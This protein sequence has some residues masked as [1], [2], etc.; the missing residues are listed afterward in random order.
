MAP[1]T[2]VDLY[3]DS[4]YKTLLPGYGDEE[5]L[6]A[7]LGAFI[8][9]EDPYI[10]TFEIYLSEGSVIATVTVSV[11]SADRLRAMFADCNVCMAFR[12][13][14]VCPRLSTV[15]E[16]EL[17]FGGNPDDEDPDKR[18]VTKIWVPVVILLL[19][20]ILLVFLCLLRRRRTRDDNS[21]EKNAWVVEEEDWQTSQKNGTVEYDAAVVGLGRFVERSANPLYMQGTEDLTPHYSVPNKS[22]VTRAADGEVAYKMAA[23][24]RPAEPLPAYATVENSTNDQDAVDYSTAHTTELR[25]GVEYSLA[26]KGTTNSVAYASACGA[27][28]L[29]YSQ[30]HGH[31]DSGV[32]TTN[33]AVRSKAGADDSLNTVKYA[34]AS[35]SNGNTAVEYCAAASWNRDHAE[36]QY[37]A[38][39]NAMIINTSVAEYSAASDTH[40]SAA[41]YLMAGGTSGERTE[42]QTATD[43]MTP[44]R[45]DLGMGEALYDPATIFSPGVSPQ[46]LF[47]EPSYA[48]ATAAVSNRSQ[49]SQL[50]QPNYA[51]AADS[52]P[53]KYHTALDRTSNDE[54]TYHMAAGRNELVRYLSSEKIMG[55][56]SIE[57]D[58]SI[59]YEMA[60]QT[61][62]RQ[63]S[64]FM[65]VCASTPPI[66]EAFSGGIA[67]LLL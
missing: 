67:L 32:H 7:L 11:E 35:N 12:E 24:N 36:P 5:E 63:V 54:S 10:T 23:N 61:N 65:C 1:V 59:V 28:D 55:A 13:S 9:R 51:L 37:A 49:A 58:D 14:M 30:A 17:V 40:G 44:G 41:T 4:D 47:E 8:V 15:P 33:Y 20:I 45:Y 57:T 18:K 50:N 25:T 38:A 48:I 16:C 19:L 46:K 53:V 2:T 26:S 62:K 52:S 64:G 3:I 22:L 31:N 60:S 39:S 6:K 29:I 43:M 42:Y 34:T 66:F 21:Q 27:G 56:V